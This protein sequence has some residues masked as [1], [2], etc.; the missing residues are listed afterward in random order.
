VS[1][2]DHYQE[3]GLFQRLMDRL[4]RI[5]RATKHVTLAQ[6]MEGTGSQEGDAV[7]GIELIYSTTG[8]IGRAKRA[9]GTLAVC[10]QVAYRSL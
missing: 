1:Y 5:V 3:Q 2:S 10:I 6:G 8:G 7:T 9:L 4:R